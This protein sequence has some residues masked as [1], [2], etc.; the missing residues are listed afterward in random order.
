MA[1]KTGQKQTKKAFRK[2]KELERARHSQ[3]EL[4]SVSP[5]T[6]S[7]R[8][9]EAMKL[10]HALTLGKADNKRLLLRGLSEAVLQTRGFR[11]YRGTETLSL[12][13]SDNLPGVTLSAGSKILTTYGEGFLVPIW[14]DL[15]QQL[16]GF[17]TRDNDPKTEAKYKWL[18]SGY[19]SHLIVNGS[20]ELPIAVIIPSQIE[21]YSLNFCEG[22]L[23]PIIAAEKLSRLFIGA[24]GGLFSTSKEQVTEAIRDYQEWLDKNCPNPSNYYLT[25][26][27]SVKVVKKRKPKTKRPTS[28]STPNRLNHSLKFKYRNKNVSGK[29][30]ATVWVD[31]GDIINSNVIQRLKNQ[32][33]FLEDLGLD[34]SIAW[35]S[36]ITKKAN[37][38][39]ELNDSDIKR[40][41]FIKPAFFF[42]QA[43]N[44]ARRKYTPDISIFENF[45]PNINF[46]DGH[47]YG[48]KSALG[49]GKT[50]ALLEW[51]KSN[52]IQ[53]TKE[54]THILFLGTRNSLLRQTIAK[55]NR[56]NKGESTNLEELD[57]SL[58]ERLELEL[59][60]FFYH[61]ADKDLVNLD[62]A[63]RLGLCVD[64]LLKINLDKI[65][66]LIIILDELISF[67]GHLYYGQT[68][69]AKRRPEIIAFFEKLI[70]KAK[71][72]IALDGNLTDWSMD[73]LKN[74]ADNKQV[75]KYENTYIAQKKHPIEI[76]LGT[77]FEEKE[78]IDKNDKRPL[79]RDIIGLAKQEKPISIGSDS[80]A[81][82][83]TLDLMLQSIGTKTLRIDSKTKPEILKAF[84]DNPDDYIVRNGIKAL[85]YSPTAES[86]LDVAIKNYFEHHFGFYFGV[87]SVNVV[88]TILQML[89]RI[90]AD[91]PTKIWVREKAVSLANEHKIVN[92]LELLKENNAQTF[93][94]QVNRILG[95]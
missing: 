56:K 64:S 41:Q 78:T 68:H 74:L 20:K 12:S 1:I 6:L 44:L 94:L 48:I 26:K 77:H 27:R 67:I 29:L 37:D 2:Q 50:T 85:F 88:D 21:S 10:I 19:S 15:K 89:A 52:M 58:E 91:I 38:C 3:K 23:K 72:V 71:L 75:I 70:K 81:L 61:I 8:S 17:Q 62:K 59:Q 24:S 43:E 82:L 4:E 63:R 54:K 46:Q 76:L 95:K 33:I 16:R 40:I 11:S 65:D 34:I 86:G 53:F 73:W 42:A 79:I 90:R 60:Q 92:C 69:I 55:A 9:L 36:Q 66:N 5:L 49:T 51:L 80:Q 45:M 13:I 57:L 47:I 14:N 31:A 18:K 39:D 32:V 22:T 28:K 25:E 87:G 30:K 7:E 35:W 83:E 84:L 93:Q